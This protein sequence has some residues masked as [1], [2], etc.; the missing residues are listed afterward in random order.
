V[1]TNANDAPRTWSQAL[2][3]KLNQ[4]PRLFPDEQ[5]AVLKRH[6]EQHE[7]FESRDEGEEE[8]KTR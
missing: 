2:E 8:N 4:G 5:R 7:C 1:K 6:N 3:L